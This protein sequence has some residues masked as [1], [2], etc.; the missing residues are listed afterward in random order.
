[1]NRRLTLLTPLLVSR[2]L[3]AFAPPVHADT[4]IE[5]TIVVDYTGDPATMMPGDTGIASITLTNG[6]TGERAAA[7]S[8]SRRCLT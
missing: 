2:I 7:T 5:P 8:L 4:E 1:M 6:A 3:L